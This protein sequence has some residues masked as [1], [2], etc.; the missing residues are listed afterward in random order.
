MLKSTVLVHG[1]WTEFL[2]L[3]HAK[4]ADVVTNGRSVSFFNN[5][6]ANLKQ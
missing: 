6:I 2:F 1:F 4:F 5:F 3:N